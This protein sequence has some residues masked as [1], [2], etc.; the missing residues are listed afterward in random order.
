MQLELK[1]PRSAF[2]SIIAI[3]SAGAAVFLFG[4]DLIALISYITLTNSSDYRFAMQQIEAFQPGGGSVLLSPAWV[5]STT[6]ISLGL[7]VASLVA[8][9]GLFRRKKWGRLSYILLAWSQAA[10]FLASSVAGYF[11][12]RSFAENSGVGQLLDS[13]SMFL[14][15][16]FAVV[17]GVIIAIAV[18]GFL[19]WKLSSQEVR[20]EFA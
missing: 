20:N 9:I 12:A 19:T 16:G 10:Y 8:S 7:N 1:P 18:A 6:V 4:T 2:V 11:F 17:I 15:S 3:T 13:S 14:A 5:L